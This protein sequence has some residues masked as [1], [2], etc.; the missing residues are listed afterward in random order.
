[1]SCHDSNGIFNVNM[2][3]TVVVMWSTM[4]RQVVDL[5]RELGGPSYTERKPRAP[6]QMFLKHLPIPV[7]PCQHFPTGCPGTP[8]PNR[9]S[10]LKA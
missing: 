6:A 10:G 9:D 8:S 4:G 7:L 5:A 1:M 3:R 2:V